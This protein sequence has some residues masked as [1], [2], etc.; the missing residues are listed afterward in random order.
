MVKI[1][2]YK[3]IINKKEKTIDDGERTKPGVEK[4]PDDVINGLTTETKNGP[5]ENRL[6]YTQSIQ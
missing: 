6:I 5:G 4:V 1:N 2:V 3:R